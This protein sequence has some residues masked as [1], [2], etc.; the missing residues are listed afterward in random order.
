MEIALLPCILPGCSCTKTW[1]L[2]LYST[3]TTT[4]EDYIKRKIYFQ[5]LKRALSYEYVLCM[6]RHTYSVCGGQETTLWSWF[7]RL[8]LSLQVYVASVL[9]GEA[10][11]WPKS[12]YLK[13]KI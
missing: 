12:V 7:Q 8:N 1:S 9:P 11:G 3:L 4:F 10:S 2:E 13:L 6:C 5:M